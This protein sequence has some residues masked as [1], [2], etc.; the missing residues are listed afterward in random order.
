MCFGDEEEVQVIKSSRLL[1]CTLVFLLPVIL[2]CSAA[3]HQR[4]LRK[5]VDRYNQQLRWSLMD[6]AQ[7]F[8]S[9]E[10][11]DNWRKSHVE[12]QKNLKI[13]SIEPRLTK[14][15]QVK[16]PSAFFKTKITWYLEDNMKVQQSV[17]HQEWRFD[18]NQWRLI[19][20]KKLGGVSSEWP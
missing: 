13:V 18:K 16:P 8:V 11:L 5:Q 9:A 10:Y 17:W 6:N 15:T 4:L 2:G 3:N 19:T 7:G 12:H 20:E 1:C 14:M